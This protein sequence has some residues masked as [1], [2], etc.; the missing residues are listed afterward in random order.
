MIALALLVA[1]AVSLVVLSDNGS[2]VDALG[3]FLLILLVAF[4]VF[5]SL[6]AVVTLG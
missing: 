4:V 2:I 5:G 1:F 6:Y 3:A